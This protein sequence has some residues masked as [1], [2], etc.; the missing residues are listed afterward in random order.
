MSD[1]LVVVVFYVL[2]EPGFLLKAYGRVD[3]NQLHTKI[4]RFF[5]VQVMDLVVLFFIKVSDQ[6][7]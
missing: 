2:L 3:C 7:G 4:Q 1:S 6:F 5:Q